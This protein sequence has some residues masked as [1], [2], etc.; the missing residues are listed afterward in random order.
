MATVSTVLLLVV[1]AMALGL[2]ALVCLCVWIY[3]DCKR[4]GGNAALWVIICIVA[5]PVIGL[6]LYLVA[7]RREIRV[8]CQNCGA[9]ID[10]RA[11]FC[12]FCGTGRQPGQMP[13]DSKRRGKFAA[14]VAA[15]VCFA[16]M[17]L[18][19]A[20]AIV[21]A[22]SSQ[23]LLD[24]LHLNTGY[25]I[26]SIT[27]GGSE[28]W[29]VQYSTAS[30]GFRYYKTMKLEDPS[31]QQLSIRVGCEGSGLILYLRQGEY[32][33]Q[34]EISGFSDPTQYSLDGF[35]EGKL[36]LCLEVQG[37]KNTKCDISIW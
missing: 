5:S 14:L 37:A 3:Q 22:I 26:G 35:S 7:G 2:A 24:D 9:M 27:T 28:D 11:A 32:E 12:E 17:I 1:L 19:M 34:I 30:D 13:N 23:V 29:H 6:I 21:T 31:R 25:T 33:E 36:E 20:G 4:R 15:A 18:L 10:D 16:A 8:P